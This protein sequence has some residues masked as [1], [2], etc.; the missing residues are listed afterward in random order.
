VKKSRKKLVISISF[1]PNE[2]GE[3]LCLEEPD[4]QQLYHITLSKN[5]TNVVTAIVDLHSK[6]SK[7]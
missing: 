2:K 1:L 3:F 4:I 6:N 7:H 5:K